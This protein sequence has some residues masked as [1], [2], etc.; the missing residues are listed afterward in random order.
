MATI[1]LPSKVHRRLANCLSSDVV[2]DMVYITGPKV[3]ARIQVAKVDVDDAAKMPAYGIIT[4]KTT[5]TECT[6]Q[7]DGVVAGTFNPNALY[8]AG[9][10]GRLLEGPPARPGAGYRRVQFVGQADDTGALDF[11]PDKRYYKVTVAP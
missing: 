10:D 11:Q 4:A 3:G 7:L 5:A 6:V 2:G 8:F 1:N 9:I